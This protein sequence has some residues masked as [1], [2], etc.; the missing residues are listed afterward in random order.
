[1]Q[2]ITFLIFI[3]AIALT[4]CEK[5]SQ[6]YE[7][8]AAGTKQKTEKLDEIKINKATAS[9]VLFGS[10]SKADSVKRTEILLNYGVNPSRASG[11]REHL[12]AQYGVGLMDEKT[13]VKRLLEEVST[14][15]GTVRY[16][17][18]VVK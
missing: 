17:F 2:K 5:T 9:C 3:V 7:K 15:P 6:D 12:E 10:T 13:C 14:T 4:G 1:M 16:D 18:T 8:E 11:L